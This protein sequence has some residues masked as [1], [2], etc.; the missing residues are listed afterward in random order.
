MLLYLFTFII[1][2]KY[3][4][5]TLTSSFVGIETVPQRK[6]KSFL[7]QQKILINNECIDS[8]IVKALNKKRAYSLISNVVH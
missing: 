7:C 1:Y 6:M 3:L 2:L 4:F 8:K 5:I